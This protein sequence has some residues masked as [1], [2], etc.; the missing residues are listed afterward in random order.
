MPHTV[1]SL[2]GRFGY[3]DDGETPNTQL[4]L[5]HYDDCKL[6]CEIRGLKTAARQDVWLGEIWYGSEGTLTRDLR[7]GLTR[8]YLGKEKEPMQ[9]AD[10]KGN[11]DLPHFQNFIA[12]LRSRKVED[13]KAD[14]LEGHVS[15]AMCHLANISHRLG[16]DSTFAPPTQALAGCKEAGE[17][18]QEAAEHLRANGIDLA[19]AKYRLGRTLRFDTKTETVPGDP[20][21]NALL[22]RT[23]RAPF[24]V[25]EKV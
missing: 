6:L 18:F 13:L 25:P 7:S 19:S 1:V 12:A 17:S 23:Y 2:A 22:T 14:C 4:A 9:L 11:K 24:I 8:V 20:E 15:S 16:K 3:D 21:A 10:G 5:Y